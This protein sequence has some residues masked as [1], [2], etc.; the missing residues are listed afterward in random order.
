MATSVVFGKANTLP[1]L[2]PLP[3]DKSPSSRPPLGAKSSFENIKLRI[4]ELSELSEL[5]DPDTDS[6]TEF[7]RN[8]DLQVIERQDKYEDWRR[9][10]ELRKTNVI[11]RISAYTERKKERI[12]HLESLVEEAYKRF[13]LDRNTTDHEKTMERI[14]LSREASKE[15][16][17]PLSRENSHLVN[18]ISEEQEISQSGEGSLAPRILPRRSVHQTPHI[19]DVR[20]G[21]ERHAGMKSTPFS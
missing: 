10:F 5:P 1:H 20:S 9:D 15:K 2:D 13:V 11:S 17:P 16:L 7:V 4:R 3:M 21:F 14:I 18:P 12:Q 19:R 8:E 6:F